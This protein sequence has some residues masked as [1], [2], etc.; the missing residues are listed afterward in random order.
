MYSGSMRVTRI[1][2]GVK[3]AFALLYCGG[4]I[5]MVA[6]APKETAKNLKPGDYI[7]FEVLSSGPALFISKKD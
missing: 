7:F 4:D 1:E 2:L 5:P 3:S 6:V